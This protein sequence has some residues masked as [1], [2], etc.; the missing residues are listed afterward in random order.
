MYLVPTGIRKIKDKL[1]SLLENGVR[2][3]TYGK[4]AEMVSIAHYC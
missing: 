1:I 2:I 3:V 4:L